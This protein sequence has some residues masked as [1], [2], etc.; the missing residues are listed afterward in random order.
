MSKVQSHVYAIV[1]EHG[2]YFF[3]E[4]K[5]AAGAMFSIEDTDFWEEAWKE[6]NQDGAFIYDDEQHLWVNQLSEALW[7]L[8]PRAFSDWLFKCTST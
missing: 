5:N 8:T 6:I 1:N 4:R 2:I 3:D 7:K